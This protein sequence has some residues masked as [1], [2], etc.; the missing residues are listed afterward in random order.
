MSSLWKNLSLGKEQLNEECMKNHIFLHV[1]VIH[2][3]DT[4]ICTRSPHLS[5]KCSHL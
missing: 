5:L 4:T 2:G 3:G 1:F